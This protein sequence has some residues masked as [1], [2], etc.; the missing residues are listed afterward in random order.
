MDKAPIKQENTKMAILSGLVEQN[1]KQ[2]HINELLLQ[3]INEEIEKA[4]Q[5]IKAYTDEQIKEIKRYIPLNDGEE[6]RL[7]QVV[8]GR[9]VAT[10]RSWLAYT[11][12][13]DPEYGGK[14]FFSKKYGHIIR[15]FYTLLRHQFGAVKYT[16]IRH[17]DFKEAIAY[18]N[19]LGLQSLPKQT[20]RITKRQLEVLNDW[21]NRHGYRL[22]I[23]GD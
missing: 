13:G 22:T 4:K 12:G 18:A 20:M 17:A 16:S 6:V 10:T 8:S 19:S 3:S 9:A 5:E 23:L 14:E 2:Q 7:K 15:S 21:E 11:F 1:G